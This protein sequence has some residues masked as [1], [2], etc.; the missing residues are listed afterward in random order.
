MAC[1]WTLRLSLSSRLP[2]WTCHFLGLWCLLA[3]RAFFA[4]FALGQ[5]VRRIGVD[6]L[7]VAPFC[8]TSMV[9]IASLLLHRF[10]FAARAEYLP[11]GNV[12]SKLPTGASG[13]AWNVLLVIP[14][15]LM[16][17]SPCTSSVTP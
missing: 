16:N 13:I 3:P 12:S 8:A 9:G 5:P 10:P 17:V 11:S 1:F 14:A 7:I 6:R 4:F 15:L 2:C